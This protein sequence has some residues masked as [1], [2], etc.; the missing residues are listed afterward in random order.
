MLFGKKWLMGTAMETES[1]V[2]RLKHYIRSEQREN[3]GGNCGALCLSIPPPD[4]FWH[5]TSSR[6]NLVGHG[7]L[8]T[9]QR[10]GENKT[11]HH[12]LDRALRKHPLFPSDNFQ[13]GGNRNETRNEGEKHRQ[14]P[15][16]SLGGASEPPPGS[17]GGRP[18]EGL[19]AKRHGG[20]LLKSKRRESN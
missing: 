11:R 1:R 7:S 16:R 14:I 4:I 8:T 17:E 19:P 6:A 13:G 20:H 9:A 5:P 18:S 2:E 10:Y 15:M 12:R 3:K